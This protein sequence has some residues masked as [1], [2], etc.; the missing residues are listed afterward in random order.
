MVYEITVTFTLKKGKEESKY[1]AKGLYFQK[2]DCEPHGK[3]VLA[4]LSKSEVL[5]LLIKNYPKHSLTSTMKVKFKQKQVNFILD[6]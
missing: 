6:S 2:T 5:D 1:Q 4:E 3:K